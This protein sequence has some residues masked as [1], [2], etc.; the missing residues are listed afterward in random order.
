MGE[1]AFARKSRVERVVAPVLRLSFMRSTEGDGDI[2][3]RCFGVASVR[4]ILR[5]LFGA[6]EGI[7]EDVLSVG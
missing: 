4:Q 5:V 6:D 3:S 2:G 1:N 7:G